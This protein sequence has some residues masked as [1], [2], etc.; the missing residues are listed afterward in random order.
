[1]DGHMN[2]FRIL[3]DVAIKM[4]LAHMFDWRADI[5]PRSNS[6]YSINKGFDLFILARLSKHSSSA[7]KWSRFQVSGPYI[8]NTHAH[9]Y[10]HMQ[11]CVGTHTGILPPLTSFGAFALI[12]QGIHSVNHQYRE[13]E[14]SQ[15]FF[16]STSGLVGTRMKNR[17]NT[18]LKVHWLFSFQPRKQQRWKRGS[19][20]GLWLLGWQASRD[21]RPWLCFIR[22]LP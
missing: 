11:T 18:N 9:I 6:F 22:I 13:K 2:H 15:D 17:A 4:T 14:Q 5:Y 19:T 8:Y 16:Q 12:L 7:E 21:T 10:T 20:C 3:Q 1:M